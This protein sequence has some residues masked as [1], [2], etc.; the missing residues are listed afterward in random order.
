MSVWKRYF[1]PGTW[2]AAAFV[3]PGTVTVCS[4]AGAQTGY[5]LL[6]AI[7]FSVLATGVLQEMAARLGLITGQGLGEAIRC[8]VPSLL[9][10]LAGGLVLTGIVLGNAAYQGGNLAGAMV[11]LQLLGGELAIGGWSLWPLTLGALAA[12]LLYRGDH[13]QITGVLTGLVLL[14]SLVF[15]LTALASGP[16]W[17]ALLQGLFLPRFPQG[18]ALLVIGLIGTTIV[19]YNLFLHAASVRE[20]WQ[21]PAD[22]PGLRTENRLAVA[23]GGLISVCI[24]LT[25]A[26]AFYAQ[27][28]PL[29]DASQ[30]AQQLSPVLGEAAGWVFALGMAAAGL[31]SAITAPL[32]A[33]Y[34][35]RGILGWHANTQDYRMRMAWG[36]VLLMGVITASLGIKPLGL[37]LVAQSANGLLLPLVAAFLLLM[38]NRPALMGSYANTRRQNLLALLVIAAVLI[39][40]A[41]TLIQILGFG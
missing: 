15:L 23:L 14:M 34:T 28:I 11:G 3:G 31:T 35:A 22:L 38:V 12:V 4:L 21:N 18:E 2:V 40:S 9:R 13:Q 29:E 19:P 16:E 6:W 7:L 37:I 33:A 36:M 10:W 26:S 5:T 24:I 32:A 8:H 39:V 25:S 30:L 41:K 20:K 17:G 27:Q 1:G